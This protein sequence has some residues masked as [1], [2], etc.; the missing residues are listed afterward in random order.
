MPLAQQNSDHVIKEINVQDVGHARKG[1]EF[2]LRNM[3][4]ERH[5]VINSFY[6]VC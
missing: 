2:H 3:R 6:E 5:F 1:Y 4:I